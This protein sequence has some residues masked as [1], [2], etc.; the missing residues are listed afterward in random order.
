[1]RLIQRTYWYLQYAVR[2]YFLRPGV[3]TTE[4][5]RWMNILSST[6]PEEDIKPILSLH[7]R[8]ESDPRTVTYPDWGAGRHN[9]GSGMV[10]RSVSQ[11]ARLSS[12][13]RNEGRL[14][15]Q[16]AKKLQPSTALELGTHLGIGTLYQQAGAP[17]CRF[18]TIEGAEALAEIAREN[19]RLTSLKIQPQLITGKFDDILPEILTEE[20]RFDYVLIDG[21]HSYN[22]TIR[23]FYML[24]PYL[25]E[26]GIIIFDDIYWS[27]GMKKA[28]DEI[29]KSDRISIALD[30]FQFGIVGKGKG[31]ATTFYL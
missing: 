24:L 7:N 11:L 31:P 18:I 26:G 20:I 12:R 14:L 27:S 4:Y 25:K 9:Q 22:P 23:Y 15:F 17:D 30:L 3:K 6:D 8:L 10:T 16:I 19:W 2:K 21:N 28:W 13:T 1:M 29:R 5:A